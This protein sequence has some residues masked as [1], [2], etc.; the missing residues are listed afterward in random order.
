M[1]SLAEDFVRHVA[2]V[3]TEES[4]AAAVAGGPAAAGRGRGSSE[5]ET[6]D[7]GGGR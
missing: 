3:E 5:G 7:M 1:A 2:A 6:A 4:L